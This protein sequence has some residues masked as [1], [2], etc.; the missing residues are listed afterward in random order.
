MRCKANVLPKGAGRT[1]QDVDDDL[2]ACARTSA[3]VYIANRAPP[4]LLV[5]D[6]GVT[7]GTDGAYDPDRLTLHTSIPL[8]VGPS[9]VYVAP[10]V[11]RDGTYGLRVF[12]V[13]F[14]SQTIFVYDPNAQALENIIRVAPGPFAMA[15]DPFSL[16]AVARHDQ[17]PFDQSDPAKGLRRYRFAYVASFTESHVQIIDLDNA[18]PDKS[19]FER[20]VF[21]L[22]VPTKPKGT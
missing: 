11:E 12:V 15:F 9:K 10:V 14:D 21:T 17:V 2:R 19:T 4:A 5:G 18:Q 8:S 13:C 7:E 6:V 22:G 1:Q 20:V 16:E 3:R